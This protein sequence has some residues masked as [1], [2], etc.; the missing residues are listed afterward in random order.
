MQLVRVEVA[1]GGGG[2]ERG[3]RGAVVRCWS[4]FVDFKANWVEG[5]FSLRLHS[6][7]LQPFCSHA[8]AC[9]GGNMETFELGVY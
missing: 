9:A 1:A 4:V 3:G 6:E 5:L 7:Q 8:A 2:R